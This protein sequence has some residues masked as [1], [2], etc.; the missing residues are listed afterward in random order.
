M[1]FYPIALL[2][3][4]NKA[5]AKDLGEESHPAKAYTG[6]LEIESPDLHHLLAYEFLSL[7]K[8]SKEQ[9]DSIHFESGDSIEKSMGLIPD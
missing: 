5:K 2:D 3:G 1:G 8:A 4:I 6:T 7:I 9:A